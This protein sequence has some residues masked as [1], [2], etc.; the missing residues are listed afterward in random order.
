MSAAANPFSPRAVLAL[1]IFG[2]LVFVALLYMIGSG[3]ASGST[4]DGGGHAA[5]KGLNG[6]AAFAAYLERRGHPVRRSRDSASLDDPGLLVLT[7]PHWMKGAELASI[8]AR[9]RQA[10]STLIVLPKWIAMQAPVG[11]PGAKRG[12]VHLGSAQAPHWEGFLDHVT[13]AVAPLASARWQGGGQAGRLPDGK[14][15]Q[16]GV[17]ERLF[18]LVRSAGDGRIL[19]AYLDDGDAGAELAG[20]APASLVQ[21]SEMADAYPV[22]LVFEPDLFNNYGMAD[23]ANARLAERLVAALDESA[24]YEGAGDEARGAIT[25]DLTLN[26]HARSRNLLTLAFTPPFLA[27]TLCLLIAAIVIGWRAF[28]RFGPARRPT[29]AIAFGKRALVANTAGLVR[30]ARRAH[31]IAPPYAAAARERLLRLLA[32]PRMPDAAAADAAIDRALAARHPDAIPFSE[33]AARLASAR[34]PHDL[35]KAAQAIHALERK[36]HR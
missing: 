10:G 2:A 15:V 6:Y 29:R 3:M 35:L 36:L 8:I 5:G 32:L 31:L 25:F 13:V 4:N 20:M 12:W 21:A 34:R 7:P 28:L 11:A 17:G 30:R 22:V 26:G 24:G 16:S 19:A 18:P 23:G 14:H 1:V 33:A 9:R 27:A